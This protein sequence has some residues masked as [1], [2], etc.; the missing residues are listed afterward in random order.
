MWQAARS[1]AASPMVR[2]RPASSG[3]AAALLSPF[4]FQITSNHLLR[5]G[6]TTVQA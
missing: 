5:F 4:G 1:L 6:V 3:A 2:R